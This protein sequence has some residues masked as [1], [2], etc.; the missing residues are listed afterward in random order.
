[1]AHSSVLRAVSKPFR[2]MLS[3]EM[4]EGEGCGM[5]GLFL[6]Y[7]VMLLQAFTSF[8]IW[9]QSAHEQ[10]TQTVKLGQQALFSEGL[11]TSLL[12]DLYSYF[13]DQDDQD[14]S[15]PAK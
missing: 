7:V 2:Q 11:Q 1:M 14:I 12:T 3:G 10:N 13:E 9:T 8:A 5:W 6:L 4:S 15:Q